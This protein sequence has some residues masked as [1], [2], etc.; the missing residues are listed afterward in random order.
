M[1]DISTWSTVFYSAGPC[2]TNNNLVKSCHVV[3]LPVSPNLL[4]NRFCT[5]QYRCIFVLVVWTLLRELDN[6]TPDMRTVCVAVLQE[7]AR[8]QST[9][10]KRHPG[11]EPVKQPDDRDSQCTCLRAQVS[12][13]LCV[14]AIT[15][16]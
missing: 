15:A 4:K 11:M 10:P 13:R 16:I 8:R 12:G 14:T 3:R 2:L 5:V 6:N 7:Y 1:S 9:K